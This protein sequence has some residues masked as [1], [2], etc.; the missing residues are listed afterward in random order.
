MFAVCQLNGH[1][2]IAGASH[3]PFTS[4]HSVLRSP[5]GSNF[6]PV[7]N[8]S[9]ELVSSWPMKGETSE[10]L[11]SHLVISILLIIGLHLSNTVWRRN[12]VNCTIHSHKKPPSPLYAPFQ[13][14]MYKTWS[15]LDYGI[16]TCQ[17]D[18]WRPLRLHYTNNA[19]WLWLC[20]RLIG[21]LIKVKL[22]ITA[23][24][25][26]HSLSLSA[27]CPL[28]HQLAVQNITPFA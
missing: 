26:S 20:D 4:T 22:N 21:L 9:S 15:R 1:V 2:G 11:W 17:E 16:I 3:W 24:S 13:R 12:F 18:S 23:I 7:G 10:Q 27:L 25:S 8:R 19:D 6:V 28:Q 5:Q 14:N